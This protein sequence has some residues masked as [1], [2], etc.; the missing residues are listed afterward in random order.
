MLPQF[1]E[2]NLTN[3]QANKVLESY[4]KQRQADAAALAEFDA[5]TAK[6]NE[7]KLRQEWGGEYRLNST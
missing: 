6:E 7:D 4:Y 5:T 2:A 1:H 3:A